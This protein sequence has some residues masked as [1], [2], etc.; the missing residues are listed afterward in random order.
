MKKLVCTLVVAAITVVSA[1]F[2]LAA[3]N[4]GINKASDD[5]VVQDTGLDPHPASYPLESQ[6]GP[7]SGIR[8][9]VSDLARLPDA[10]VLML[11]GSARYRGALPRLSQRCRTHSGSY[12]CAMTTLEQ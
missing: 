11:H 5:M 4:S 12:C 3:P 1:N 9:V 7:S 6:L 10:H 2:A 8:A